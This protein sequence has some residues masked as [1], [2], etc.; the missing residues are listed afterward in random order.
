MFVCSMC[1]LFVFFISVHILRYSFHIFDLLI[2]KFV[3]HFK[4]YF[5]LIISDITY[6]ADIYYFLIGHNV[7]SSSKSEEIWKLVISTQSLTTDLLLSYDTLLTDL[8]LASD[9]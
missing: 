5:S 6:L 1:I 8:Q 3:I 2:D 4:V 9:F 7:I